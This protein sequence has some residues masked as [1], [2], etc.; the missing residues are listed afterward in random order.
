MG[1]VN[2]C[3]DILT[4]MPFYPEFAFNNTYGVKAINETEYRAKVA[5]FPECRARVEKC[6][7]L[8]EA[9]DPLGSGSVKE[10]NAA[11]FDANKFCF[12]NMW[13]GV[14]DRGVS[15]SSPQ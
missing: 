7:S 10:V 11:C 13:T 9:K 15:D 2:G 1:I 3:I 4:Q 12:D 8:V 6:R 14:Q 5:A